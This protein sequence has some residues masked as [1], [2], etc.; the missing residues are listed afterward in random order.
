MAGV[1]EEVGRYVG[2]RY[3]LKQYREWKDGV[4]YGIGHGG[5]EAILLGVIG[6]IQI[7]AL[8]AILNAGQLDKVQLPAS[9]LPLITQ[10]LTSPSWV[11]L[12][13]GFERI[14]AFIVHIGLSLVVL[15][16]VTSGKKRFLVYAIILHAVFD[17]LP[18]MYQMKIAPLWLTEVIVMLFALVTLY[19]LK[20]SRKYFSSR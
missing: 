18:A 11:F 3:L 5:I 14:F 19:I 2:M 9:S 6:N 12:I 17:L 16:S 7:L 1:F 13:S 8:G 15:Y 20:D 10:L 4:A